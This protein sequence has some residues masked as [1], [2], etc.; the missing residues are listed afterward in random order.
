MSATECAIGAAAEAA[1]TPQAI[2]FLP[3]WRFGEQ[4]LALLQAGSKRQVRFVAPERPAS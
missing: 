3:E 2:E 1:L 4:R